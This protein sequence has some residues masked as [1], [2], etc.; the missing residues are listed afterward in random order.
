MN[1]IRFGGELYEMRY[2][3]YEMKG[4]RDE[5]YGQTV[6]FMERRGQPFRFFFILEEGEPL[7]LRLNIYVYI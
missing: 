4:K 2:F 3:L 5:V 6:S 1:P 7:F